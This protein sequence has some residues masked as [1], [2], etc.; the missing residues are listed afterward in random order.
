MVNPE[1]VV[2]PHRTVAYTD[3]TTLA[4]PVRSVRADGGRWRGV[5]LIEAVLYV[6]VALALIVGG[7]VFFQQV[8][9]AQRTDNA[10][11]NISLLASESR[12]L[13][14]DVGDFAGLDTMT[15]LNAGAIPAN[16]VVIHRGTPRV[17]NEWGK[18]ITVIADMNGTV[19]NAPN[20][21]FT[22]IYSSIPPSACVRLAAFDA[23]GVGRVGSGI[24][25]VGLKPGGE[26]LAFAGGAGSFA[27]RTAAEGG[28]AP[29]EA[30]SSCNQFATSTGTVD[31]R[32][33]FNK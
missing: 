20:T 18:P 23:G 7:L 4:L 2:F 11:R 13:F 17:V 3:A 15:L 27:T 19:A 12:A 33:R 9:R 5:T 16:L 14:Q 1:A 22:I 10:A 31:L 32:F 8:S 21:T 30:A 29:G 26:E 28:F 25:S 6:S 24:V